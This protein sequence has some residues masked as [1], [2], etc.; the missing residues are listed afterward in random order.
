[1][2]TVLTSYNSLNYVLQYQFAPVPDLQGMNSLKSV[3][4]DAKFTVRIFH[5]RSLIDYFTSPL[6][7]I[8]SLFTALSG[9][10][11]LRTNISQS[12][13][14]LAFV[15]FPRELM[16]LLNWKTLANSVNKF[17]NP[18]RLI[19]NITGL[20]RDDM[21]ELQ[22]DEYLVGLAEKGIIRYT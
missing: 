3:V 7:W 19:L 10:P 8:T 9:S 1:M 13:L 12:T 5:H 6:P 2:D 11:S 16:K 17:P 21:A 22:R 14:N 20:N 15:N 4:I 18:P